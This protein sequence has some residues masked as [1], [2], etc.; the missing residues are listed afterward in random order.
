LGINKDKQW[1]DT[2]GGVF[3][4]FIDKESVVL[5]RAVLFVSLW[6]GF[7]NLTQARIFLGK[8]NLH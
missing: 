6:F 7:L 2:V 3:V 8:R 5:V 1:K 4:C